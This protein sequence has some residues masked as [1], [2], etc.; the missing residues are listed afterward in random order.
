LPFSDAALF[1]MSSP[2]NDS[3]AAAASP[4]ADADAAVAPRRVEDDRGPLTT[5]ARDDDDD[6][7]RRDVSALARSIARAEG[8]EGAIDAMARVPI[9]ARSCSRAAL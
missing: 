6:D 8:A 5:R 4:A 1:A 9:F 7:A 3:G 2:S